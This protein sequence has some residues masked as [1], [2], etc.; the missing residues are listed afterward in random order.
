[1]LG[2]DVT[3]GTG[4]GAEVGVAAGAGWLKTTLN[5]DED[6]NTNDERRDLIH[7]YCT[8]RQREKRH[9]HTKHHI[10]KARPKCVRAKTE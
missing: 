5:S 10:S 9:G 1:M 7:K 3:D 8:Y 4:A 2:T 6:V